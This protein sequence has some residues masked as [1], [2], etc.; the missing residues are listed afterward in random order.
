VSE[1][2]APL[3]ASVLQCFGEENWK[4]QLVD[5]KKKLD[6]QLKSQDLAKLKPSFTSDRL[7]MILIDQFTKPLEVQHYRGRDL[8]LSREHVKKC[9]MMFKAIDEI[10]K[11]H[12]A[13]VKECEERQDQEALDY[14]SKTATVFVERCN[15]LR[16]SLNVAQLNHLGDE[17]NI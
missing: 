9:D 14:H 3:R 13:K 6:G 5:A 4:L 8:Q 1:I 16:S 11:E 17:D 7:S 10:I 2:H 15:L 12:L